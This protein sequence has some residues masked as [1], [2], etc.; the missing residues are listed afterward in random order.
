LNAVHNKLTRNNGKW[1]ENQI[2][3]YS[4]S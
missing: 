2:Y 3:Y 1:I 4:K